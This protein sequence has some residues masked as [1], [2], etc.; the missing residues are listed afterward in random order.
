MEEKLQVQHLK[1]D[2]VVCFHPTNQSFFTQIWLKIYYQHD[3]T[4]LSK[5]S[6]MIKA[7]SWHGII[8]LILS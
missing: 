6:K 7:I 1:K 4:C 2:C 3:E 8:N 5:M